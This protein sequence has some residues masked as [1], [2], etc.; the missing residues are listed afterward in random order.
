MKKVLGIVCAAALVCSLAGCG[1]Q[2]DEPA[3]GTAAPSQVAEPEASP[4]DD[5]VSVPETPASETADEPV[6]NRTIEVTANGTTIAFELNDSTAA[7]ALLAQLPLTV[8]VEDYS[9]NE[10][11]FYPPESL[12]TT[13]APQA[14]GGPGTLAYYAPWGDV[15]MFY[16]SYAP[17]GG[18][19]E[20]GQAVS[21]ADAIRNLSGTIEISAAK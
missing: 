10:K 21:G 13:G 8:P 1:A 7:N 16:G 18:L 3:D 4:A 20:L 9:T 6:Q 2:G 14:E 19:Y 17:N 12:D 11:I 15:V 5:G